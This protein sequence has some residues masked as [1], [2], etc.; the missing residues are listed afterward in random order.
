[1]KIVVDTNII[2]SGLMRED[3]HF[4]NTIIK[5]EANHTFYVV[6]FTIVELF[7]HKERI[8]KF[9]KLSENEILEAL[10]ELLKHITIINDDIIS[11]PSWKQSM[12]LVHD[13]DIKDVP[14]VALTIELEGK[15]WTG[16]IELKLGLRAKGF[17]NFFELSNKI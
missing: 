17:D 8:V 14:N 6:Y 2:F 5:N 4:A 16:D 7:K 13:V 12:Q 11:V 10:Y 1:M 15:L 9:S 3:N